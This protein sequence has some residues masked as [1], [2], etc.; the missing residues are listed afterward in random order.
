VEVARVYDEE[1]VDVKPERVGGAVSAPYP[2][3]AP[4]LKRGRRVSILAS[5]V[6]TETGDVTDI[7]VEEGGGVLDAV[8]LEVSR[9]KYRPGSKDGVPVKVRMRWR[10]TYIG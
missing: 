10:H 4:D 6:V 8:L 3:W 7:R 1:D 2:E 9:W 5:Y